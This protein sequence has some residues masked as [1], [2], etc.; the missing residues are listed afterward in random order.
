M[1]QF[2]TLGVILD[3]GLHISYCLVDLSHDKKKRREE[4]RVLL[5]KLKK[6]S[7]MVRKH[8]LKA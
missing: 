8:M 3:S 4:V 1:A 2:K 6:E 7:T 5:Q